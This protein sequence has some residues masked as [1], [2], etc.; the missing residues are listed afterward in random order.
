MLNWLAQYPLEPKD[1][2][3]PIVTLFGFAWAILQ[4]RNTARREFVRPVREAQLKL[5][6]QA[7]SAAAIL[8]TAP[9]KSEEW[10]TAHQE[11]LRLYYG[12][13]AIVE[14]FDHAPTQGNKLTVEDAMIIFRAA[15]DNKDQLTELKARLE[16]LSLALAHSCRQSLG[17][18]WGYTP[19]Q[20]LGVYQDNALKFRQ[21]VWERQ[22]KLSIQSE[23]PGYIYQQGKDKKIELTQTPK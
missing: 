18:S 14:N 15:I 1:L 9:S 3:T 8:A 7:A 16:H 23:A 13:L 22:T 20:L 6:Q 10:N 5:Y 21:D 2:L 12:P 4:Y 11:F 17:D 19:Q